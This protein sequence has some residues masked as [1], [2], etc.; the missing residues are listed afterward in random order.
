M[1]LLTFKTFTNCLGT[2]SD[3]F[4]TEE[5]KKSLDSLEEGSEN[6]KVRVRITYIMNLP[7]K[8]DTG[9]RIST[10]SLTE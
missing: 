3:I 2:K 7:C 9:N 5:E 10:T 8:E 4:V 6:R 1:T